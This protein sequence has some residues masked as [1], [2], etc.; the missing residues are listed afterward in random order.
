MNGLCN[1]AS[2]CSIYTA[3]NYSTINEKLLGKVVDGSRPGQT[4]ATG[5][6]FDLT[7]IGWHFL[8][9]HLP[10]QRKPHTQRSCHEKRK[11]IAVD[12]KKKYPVL[13]QKL[14]GGN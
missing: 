13:S 1:D 7:T 12:K 4:R 5:Q 6:L 11:T 8:S 9:A 3:P 10:Y 14:L 2:N